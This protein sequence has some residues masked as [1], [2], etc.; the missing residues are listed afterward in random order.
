MT[1]GTVSTEERRLMVYRR[2]KLYPEHIE[3]RSGAG[4]IYEPGLDET[5]LLSM[6]HNGDGR[7]GRPLETKEE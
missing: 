5:V 7:P 1:L 2:V 3:S 4:E 6:P